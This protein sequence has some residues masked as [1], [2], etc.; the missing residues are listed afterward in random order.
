MKCWLVVPGLV[1]LGACATDLRDVGREPHMTA[2]GTG[3]Q[4]DVEGLAPGEFPAPSRASN[5]SLWD[6]ER[7]DLFHDPRATRVG[8]VVTVTISINDKATLDN[9]SGRSETA[10]ATNG[11]DY[12]VANGSHTSK[13]S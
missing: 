12:N 8:D 1:L 13:G 3:L 10:K 6:N 9:T 11:Y 2:V 4:A 5:Q 7:A